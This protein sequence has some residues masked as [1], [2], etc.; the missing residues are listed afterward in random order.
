MPDAEITFE[1]FKKKYHCESV[2]VSVL[3]AAKW[4]NG[5]Q[6]PRCACRHVTV[7][8]TRRLPLYECRGCK[9]QSSLLRGTV[10]EGSRTSL[11]KWFQALFL[12]GSPTCSINAVQL[13]KLISVTYKTAWLILHKLRHAIR[14][15]DATKLLTGL[16][17]VISSVYNPRDSFFR[18]T[19]RKPKKHQHPVIVGA[20]FYGGVSYVK[21][22]Q[23][24]TSPQHRNRAMDH[25]DFAHFLHEHVHSTVKFPFVHNQ[26]NHHKASDTLN[27][28][29]D[30]VTQRINQ[31]YFGVSGKHL[32]AYLDET[33]FRL[34]HSLRPNRAVSRLFR[35]FISTPTITYKQLI[36]S[37]APT[38]AHVSA[39]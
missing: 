3:H 11:H 9:Y 8:T 27:M 33:S 20:G 14:H 24:Y 6:C 17:E 18:W 35:L 16:V 12:I 25:S 21:F 36:A 28:I 7:I 39:A 10:I 5:F 29:S 2:C 22:K 23:V 34:N 1:Q 19:E 15:G 32:Q 4:P 13:S 30:S 38:I 31:R 37:A 26:F